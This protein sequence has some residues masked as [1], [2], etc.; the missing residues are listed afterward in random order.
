M[1]DT[2]AVRALRSM[3]LIPYVLENPGVSIAEL[4]AKFSVTQAQIESDLQLV[5]MCGLPGYTPYELID[6]AFEDGVVSII[7]PQV[8]DKPR[9]FSSNEIVVIALGLKILIDINQT[10]TTAL[11]KLKQ[12]SEKIAKLGS[13]KSILMT[14]DV[15]AFPF[16]EIITKA[17]SEQRVLDL[18]YHS[19]TKDEI[20][21]R[22]VLPEKL[23]FLNGS[24]YLS[25]IDTAIDSDRVFKVDLIKECKIGERVAGKNL[26]ESSLETTV[27]LDVQRQNRMFIERNSSI[28][29]AMQDNGD[30]IR[31]H[32]QVSS[33]EWIKL[34][35]LS[36]APGITVVSP[37][38]LA[39]A[40][41][42]SARDLLALY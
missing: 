40:V 34:T 5:F 2:A 36:N 22:K 38:S 7:D 33:L 21:Q 17:I 15:N 14:G 10:N 9:K 28:I 41:E 31:V 19:L 20:T 37:E 39:D 6:V 23:Y 13:N 26:L 11:T 24:L 18:Q 16:F 8:L 42:Q 12:L 35:V 32:L 30:L 29:T 25:A 3:D 27:V 4:S 1:V